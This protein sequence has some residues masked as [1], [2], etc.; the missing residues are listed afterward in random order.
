MT[1]DMSTILKIGFATG[2]I[3][4]DSMKLVA[5]RTHRSWG[6]RTNA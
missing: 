3:V 4:L 1:R 2:S 6:E 5:E